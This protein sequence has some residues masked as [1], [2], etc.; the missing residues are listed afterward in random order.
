MEGVPHQATALNDSFGTTEVTGKYVAEDTE[1]A[2]A[3][4]AYA[5]W[6]LK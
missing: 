3:I 4:F 2:K 1:R 5:G 6:L